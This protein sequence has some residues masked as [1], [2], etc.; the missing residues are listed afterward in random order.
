MR[1]LSGLMAAL[2]LSLPMFG[3]KTLDIYF[4]DVEGGQATL[5]VTPARQSMLVDTGWPGFNGRD[6]GRIAAA[7]KKAGVKKID[8]LV[9]SHYHTDHVGGVAQLLERLPVKTFVDHGPTV[10]TGKNATEL[11]AMYEKAAQTGQRL[12]VKP[13]DRIP[14]K[15]VE[16]QVVTANGATIPSATAA[17]GAANEFCE[18]SASYPEDKGENARSVGFVLTMGKFRFIDLGDLTSAKE[19]DLVCPSNRVGAVDVY[20]TTHHGLDTSNAKAIVHGLRPRVAIMNNGAKKGGVPKA[21]QTIKNSPG[22][23]DMWQVH[24]AL[25]GGKETNVPEPMI[26][27]LEENCEGK[28]LQLSA[29]PDGSF[30]VMNSR[31]KFQKNYPA[32]Q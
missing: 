23:E 11:S 17:G 32:K 2:C 28:H 10:E 9:T 7:A 13:G 16:V 15:G 22:L 29:L 25:A 3:A 30:T 26:A 24:F 6:A 20:L 18:A 21:W 12:V 14:L 5:I 31:N 8:Y 27:N 19:M 1:K 4:V